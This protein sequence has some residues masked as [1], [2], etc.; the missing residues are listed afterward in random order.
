LPVPP[1]KAAL[2]LSAVSQRALFVGCGEK[3]TLTV[4]AR[5]ETARTAPPFGDAVLGVWSG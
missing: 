2:F 5:A 3:C 1:G 4:P